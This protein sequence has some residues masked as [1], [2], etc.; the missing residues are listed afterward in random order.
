MAETFTVT[1]SYGDLRVDA[2]TGDVLTYFCEDWAYLPGDDE[3]PGYR[4]IVRFDVDEWRRF[5]PSEKLD[6]QWVDILDIGF[7]YMFLS[8]SGSTVLLDMSQ[9]SRT[10]ATRS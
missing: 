7:W 5:Y 9:R 2:K 4:D 10:G 1:G 8:V 6:D 3:A